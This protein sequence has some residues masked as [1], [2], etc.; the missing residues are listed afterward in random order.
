[1]S[2]L[3]PILAAVGASC[4]A[5][6]ILI[7]ILMRRRRTPIAWGAMQFLLEAYRRQRRRMRLEQILLL[8][9]R[10]LLVLLLALAL[11]KPVLGDAGLAAGR[12]ARIAFLLIDNSLTA[13]ATAGSA[14]EAELEHLKAR[15]AGVLA[16][17]DAARGDR[18]AL[19][20][21]AG[22]AEAVVGAPTSD[23]SGVGELLRGLRPHD[24]RA[25]IP[26]GLA[27]VRS[28]IT[29]ATREE[30]GTAEVYVLSA[31]R[32]G[33]ADTSVA[34][35]GA[36][37]GTE[38]LRVYASEPASV[39][40][41]N[42]AITDVTPLR[43]VLLTGAEAGDAVPTRFRVSLARH[44]PGVHTA[45]VTTLDLGVGGAADVAPS[46]TRATVP[47]PVGQWTTSA[48][49]TVDVPAKNLAA[50]RVVATAR[51][52]RDA[53]AGDNV[54]CRPLDV[55]DH[56]RVAL[57]APG[58]PGT[59]ATLAE[60]TAGDWLALGLS[61]DAG[62]TGRRGGGD[63]RLEVVEPSRAGAAAGLVAESDAIVLARP[64]LLD[65][66]AWSA[67]R[68]GAD[69]GA[70]VIVIPPPQGPHLWPDAMNQRLGVDLTL[71]REP[72]APAAPVRFSAQAGGTLLE[73]LSAELPDLLQPVTVTRVL[74]VSGTPG[75]WEPI[76]SLDDGRPVIVVAQPTARADAP[77]GL[78]VVF[79]VSL[80][81]AWT[82]LPTKPLMVPLLQE[83]VRQGVGRTGGSG[84]A[85]A[86]TPPTLAPAAAE[87]SLVA[88]SEDSSPGIVGVAQG[89]PAAAL[90]DASVYAARAASGVTL[91]L[92]AVNAD[93]NG[94][95]TRTRS[96]EEIARWLAGTGEGVRWLDESGGASG[97]DWKART[98]DLPPISTPLLA[99]ALLLAIG[100][101]FLGRFFSHARSA[102]RTGGA[103]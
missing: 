62:L 39:E 94:S 80:D 71:A 5:V 78:V 100:E 76:L 82:D 68:T 61:P 77:R 63:V 69:R 55:R 60:F 75:A 11:G 74:P 22:P 41:D 52:D 9:A 87:L 64:D 21:L 31:W 90:R 3:N 48:I 49:V 84:T 103:P 97:G 50:G 28:A 27:L 8:T 51:I 14:S 26:G 40:L 91:G 16:G 59:A 54:F 23:L 93:T 85:V 30:G 13:S 81:V 101:A 1:M 19:I 43:R 32:E 98:D 56:L 53:V 18:A 57:L 24:S 95:Y 47:W 86:G 99:G 38:R 33:S 65:A 36:A 67:V 17:L 10:C 12:R 92:L 58:S 72:E 45:D 66:E 15:A 2:F 29:Q 73:S 7:H 70:L 42:T 25:D 79:A 20:A 83:I 46:R 4:V 88:G 37:Q 35:T 96:R 34:I 44:G 102:A 89:R 6:P